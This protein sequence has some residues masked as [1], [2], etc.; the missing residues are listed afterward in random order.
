MSGN[1]LAA[2]AR[3][4]LAAIVVFCGTSA[5]AVLIDVAPGLGA[6]VGGGLALV[7]VLALCGIALAGIRVTWGRVVIALT[8][9]VVV[10]ASLAFIDWLG[11]ADGRTHLGHFVQ[12][13]IDGDAGGV[14]WR[15]AG[16]V[17][18][19]F[20]ILP[21]TWFTLLVLGFLIYQLVAFRREPPEGAWR[22]LLIDRTFRIALVGSLGVLLLGGA[23]NDYGL[24]VATI[25]LLL[26]V[27][28]VLLYGFS[29]GSGFAKLHDRR[30]PHLHLARNRKCRTDPSS[31]QSTPHRPKLPRPML[32]SPPVRARNAM[33]K[34]R[35]DFDDTKILAQ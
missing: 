28:L 12:Q 4:K 26:L 9:G 3:R 22:V 11:P 34:G 15:K 27:P 31:P 14:I 30:R 19:S 33:V 20:T 1:G 5:L 16:Y 13:V 25:G 18:R 6:D 24:R 10:V 8:A 23:L 17:L 7:P 2:S 35:R 29:S 32:L 21:A